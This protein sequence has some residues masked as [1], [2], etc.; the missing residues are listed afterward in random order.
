M[1]CRTLFV[2]L[3]NIH[4]NLVNYDTMNTNMKEKKQ[5]KEIIQSYILTV[6][7]YESN[8]YVKRILTHIVAANQNYLEGSKMPCLIN[9]EEDLFKNRDYTL[10]VK[11][12]L[13]NNEDKNYA[14]VI[15]AFHYLQGKFLRFDDEDR[16]HV[17]VPF[18][19]GLLIK[20]NSGVAK[21]CM[22]ELTYK[23]FMDF[24]RG[25]RKLEFE[26][27]LSF[28]SVYSIRFYELMSGQTKPYTQTFNEL[29]KMFGLEDKYK[30]V[31]DFIKRVIEPAKKEL[32]EK[33]PVAFEYKI[34]K[35]G[36]SYHSITFFPVATL[37]KSESFI[38]AEDVIAR[39]KE[40]LLKS[41]HGLSELE[42][43]YLKNLGFTEQQMKNNIS[44]LLIA[45][46]HLDLVY[47]LSLL[48]G[49]VR[50]KNNPQGYV[51]KTL[52]GKVKDKR[53]KILKK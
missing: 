19:T 30:N 25:Y 36:R 39:E 29:R 33:S 44:T 42:Q 9:V 23:A 2:F 31:N 51:V 7:R 43:T 48:V 26:L 3:R 32:D 41:K 38:A 52:R 53:T 17:S 27:T 50:E 47:E 16:N 8:I 20:R 45:K 18:I 14:R 35:L 12:I 37:N 6:A 40:E 13:T 10:D 5:N 11:N 22:S 15:E 49:K 4:Q 28:N 34:N 24:S 21:F 46:Q 1:L